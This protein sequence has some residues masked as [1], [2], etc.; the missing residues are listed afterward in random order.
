MSVTEKTAYISVVPRETTEEYDPEAM[1]IAVVGVLYDGTVYYFEEKEVLRLFDLLERAERYVGVNDYIV[2]ALGPYAEDSELS[3][4]VGI[5][6]RVSDSLGERVSLNNV[7]KATLG[8]ERDDPRRLPLEWS[9]GRER[10]VR[11]SVKKDLLILRDLDAAIHEGEVRVT[12][13]R[14]ME[15]RTVEFGTED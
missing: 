3:P 9:E 11:S 1:G 10:T 13:P 8:R 15:E 5:Q 6:K 14:T 4:F 12:D 2:D 7:T